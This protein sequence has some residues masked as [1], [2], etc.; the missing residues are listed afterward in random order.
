MKLEQVKRK[1][2][3]LKIDDLAKRSGFQ[4]REPR[5]IDIVGLIGGFWLTM[6][7]PAFSMTRW[8]RNIGLIQDC[9]VSKQAL[10]KRLCAEHSLGQQLLEKVLQHP[11]SK[12]LQIAKDKGLFKSF[13]NVL[14]EDSTCISLP[15]TLAKL[16]PG[17]HNRFGESATARIQ[18]RMSLLDE[19]YSHIE[20]HSFRYN[21]AKYAKQIVPSLKKAD[22]VIRDLGYWSLAVFK[23]IADKGAFFLSR[24]R[25]GT[26]LMDQNGTP[27]ALAKR[28][29]K[30]LKEGKTI[31]DMPILIGQKAQLPV[32]FVAIKVPQ[33]I[34]L[35]RKRAAKKNRDRRLKHKQDYYDLLDWTLFITNVEVNTWDSK[36]ILQAYRLRWRIEM[37]FKCWKSKLKFDQL[38]HKKQSFNPNGGQLIV[39]LALA[40]L[41]LFY[42][43]WYNYFA[44]KVYEQTH[45]F[46]SPF[47]F[48]DFV[49]EHFWELLLPKT[50][51]KELVPWVAYYCT[52]ENRTRQN[53]F[54]LLYYT[55][56]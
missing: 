13:T 27:I 37:I 32:R 21:D 28:L 48:A 54:D 40:T 11:L 15:T 33:N 51:W 55:L 2:S 4:K 31:V 56:S 20:L 42:A 17:S 19:Q 6:F 16:F 38:F 30:A 46:V 52:Y 25:Y 7:S 14:I 35:Q 26:S 50:K 29:K 10:H 3:K 8:S 12:P 36:S 45:K 53:H 49:K 41:A 1:I 5:K 9:F 34:A 43:P 24:Y 22:L 18:L 23:Q 39:Y 47:K 44:V